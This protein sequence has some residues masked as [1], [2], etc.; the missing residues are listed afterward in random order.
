MPKAE[1]G[2]CVLGAP[3]G[4]QTVSHAPKIFAKNKTIGGISVWA[5]FSP[6][7]VCFSP[8]AWPFVTYQQNVSAA[9]MKIVPLI[10][11]TILVKH[12]GFN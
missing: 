6:K 4:R 1:E 12:R 9:C 11:A 8:N 3:S 5:E 7:G 10:V 2:V